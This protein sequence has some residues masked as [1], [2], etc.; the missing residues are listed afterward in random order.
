MS[1]RLRKEIDIQM[2]ELRRLIEKYDELFG[3]EYQDDPGDIVTIALAAILHSFYTGIEGIFKR[4]AQRIDESLPKG[5]D[6][7]A[8]LLET[9][10]RS[11]SRRPP[12]ISESLARTLRQYMDFRHMF[13]HAY[14]NYLVW[15][16]M[17]PLVR[18][19]RQTFHLFEAELTNFL[20]E[21]ETIEK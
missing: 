1:T 18:E 11:S 21:I 20:N 4:I 9:M 7:H 5:E 17:E 3:K 10:T 8:R 14:A 16:R 15:N 13:R 6:Y 2:S 12:V 19:C